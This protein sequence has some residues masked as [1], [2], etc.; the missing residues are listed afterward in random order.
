MKIALA[1]LMLATPAL[2]DTLAIN[3]PTGRIVVFKETPTCDEAER[4]Y[5]ARNVAPIEAVVIDRD[6]IKLRMRDITEAI[7]TRTYGHVGFVDFDDQRRRTFY[8][9]V[10]REALVVTFGLIVRTQRE[11]CAI[12]WRADAVRPTR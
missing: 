7:P 8:V 1:L 4:A 6:S 11:P 2:A 9:S 3:H 12:R 5:L 10:D